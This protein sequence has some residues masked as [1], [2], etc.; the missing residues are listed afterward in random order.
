MSLISSSWG[1]GL[2]ESI[3]ASVW[4]PRTVPSG[5]I[6]Y[7]FGLLFLEFDLFL[8][9]RVLLFIFEVGEAGSYA[10]LIGDVAYLE[11]NSALL[12]KLS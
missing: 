10:F 2:A 3:P 12:Y 1:I 9:E 7:F 11:S 4:Y 8:V 5:A 6:K